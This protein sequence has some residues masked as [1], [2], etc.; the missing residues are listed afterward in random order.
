MNLL[1]TNITGDQA[2]GNALNVAIIAVVVIFGI[3][4]LKPFPTK[5][6]TRHGLRGYTMTLSAKLKSLNG[7][8]IASGMN[9]IRR[10]LTNTSLI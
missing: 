4:L 2:N 3:I 6:K 9:F 10:N 1:Q 5:K 8:V 7:I